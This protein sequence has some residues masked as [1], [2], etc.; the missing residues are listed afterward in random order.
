M[1]TDDFLARVQ[2]SGG[3]SSPEDAERWSIA[4]LTSLG[5]LLSDSETRRHF[6]SQLPGRLKS[7]VLDERPRAVLMTRDAFLQHIGSA[8]GVHASEAEAALRAVWGVLKEA[9]SA[10]EISDL[11]AHIPKDIL[12]LLER[13]P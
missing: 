11:S 12:T 7:R 1:K 10:G 6:A 4:V 9:V 5:H 3:L 2:D 8:L 13:R